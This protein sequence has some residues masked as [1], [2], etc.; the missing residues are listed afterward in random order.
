M[1]GSWNNIT[2]WALNL[3]Q[4]ADSAG[5]LTMTRAITITIKEV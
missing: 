4:P 1:K 3:C 5:L 2:P